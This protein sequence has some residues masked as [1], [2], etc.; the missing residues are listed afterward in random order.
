MQGNDQSQNKLIVDQKIAD[1]T[2]ELEQKK[3]ASNTLTK[4]LKE[5][6]V[7]SDGLVSVL[8]CWDE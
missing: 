6:E 7:G 4:T 1:L 5:F 2:C 8:D 3:K